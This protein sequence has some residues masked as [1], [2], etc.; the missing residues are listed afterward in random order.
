MVVDFVYDQLD[1]DWYMALTGFVLIAV[2]IAGLMNPD[3]WVL[4]SAPFGQIFNLLPNIV[5]QALG[6]LFALGGLSQV[7]D[8]FQ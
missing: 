3:S 2:G 4:A 8:V 6:G 7:V 5:H 1:T